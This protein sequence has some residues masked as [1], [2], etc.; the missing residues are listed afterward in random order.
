MPDALTTPRLPPIAGDSI[1]MGSDVLNFVKESALLAEFEA[2]LA[3][4]AA[5]FKAIKITVS[6]QENHEEEFAVPK[7]LLQVHTPL[8]RKEFRAAMLSFMPEIKQRLG[9]KIYDSLSV[10]KD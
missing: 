1:Q 3:M 9:L 8:D 6:L 2:A 5:R 10:L 4:A 7:V